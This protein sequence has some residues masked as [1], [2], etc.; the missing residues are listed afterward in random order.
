MSMEEK[1][2]AYDLVDIVQLLA[3]CTQTGYSA[4]REK[5]RKAI[6]EILE[7]KPVTVRNLDETLPGGE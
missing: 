7:N 1:L 6:I 5:A 4:D 2:E 3:I